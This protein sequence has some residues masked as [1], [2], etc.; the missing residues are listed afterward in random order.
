M[1]HHKICFRGFQIIDHKSF[2]HGKNGPKGT[3][4]SLGN[5]CNEAIEALVGSSL[6]ISLGKSVIKPEDRAQQGMSHSSHRWAG[7]QLPQLECNMME[8]GH[9]TGRIRAV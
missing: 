8:V 6:V 1:A 9:H 3:Q 2:K 4:S 7:R 5:T